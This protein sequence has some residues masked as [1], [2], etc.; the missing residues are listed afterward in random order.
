[1]KWVVFF[2]CFVNTFPQDLQFT[3]CIKLKLVW[4]VWFLSS[5]GNVE[6]WYLTNVLR[7]VL[8]FYISKFYKQFL[9]LKH[10]NKKN[11]TSIIL[12]KAKTFLNTW[13]KEWGQYAEN[14]IKE[15]GKGKD[16]KGKAYIRKTKSMGQARIAQQ[17]WRKLA[18][19]L[20]KIETRQTKKRKKEGC[21][22]ALW[23]CVAKKKVCKRIVDGSHD[24]KKSYWSF[25]FH[26]KPINIKW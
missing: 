26:V 11:S 25:L 4:K 13:F 16:Y 7:A 23:L 10:S 3:P 21:P 1:M 12:S 20:P 19:N 18:R 15:K 9:N 22:A 2:L 24:K 5:Q 17:Y 6:L 8:P 14:I